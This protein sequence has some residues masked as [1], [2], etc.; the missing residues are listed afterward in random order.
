MPAGRRPDAR[1]R[2]DQAVRAAIGMSDA[3]CPEVW[4]VVKAERDG[5][6]AGFAARVLAAIG[7]RKA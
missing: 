7:E 1:R 3:D 5:D 6:V 4:A 2:L